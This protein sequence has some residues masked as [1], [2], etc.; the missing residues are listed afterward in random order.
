MPSKV[1]VFYHPEQMKQGDNMED[2]IFCKIAAG[3]IKSELLYHD[4]RVVAFKDIHP[5]TPV[6]I[7]IIP[8]EHIASL[9]D[10]NEK[11]EVLMGHMVWV[12]TKLAR[13]NLIDRDGYRVVIN[14]GEHGT[15]IIKHVH[16]HLLG[17]RQL[18]PG[19]V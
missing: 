10:I 5:V 4:D 1:E 16:L 13:E 2:C 14:V 15:Q 17:G 11:H 8:R 12:A 6:H 7:L 18:A 19:M 9:A 3:Q